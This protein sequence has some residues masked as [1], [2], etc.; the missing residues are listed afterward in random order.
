MTGGVWLKYPLPLMPKGE[1]KL[2]KGYKKHDLRGSCVAKGSSF[3]GGALVLSSM[4][5]GEIVD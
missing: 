3:E 1:K 5:K 4:T 2:S